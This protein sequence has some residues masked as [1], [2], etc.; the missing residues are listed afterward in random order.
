M[1]T[2]TRTNRQPIG[3][4]TLVL[5]FLLALSAFINYVD[6]GNLSVAAP[7]L[8]SELR[9]SA[10]QLGNLLAA[11]FWTYTFLMIFTGW[12]VDCFPVGW[13][14]AAG[15]ALWSFATVAT[16]LVNSFAML[17]LFRLLLG[18][19][20]SVSFPAYGKILAQHVA[21]EH[22]GI[23][24]AMVISGMSLGPAAGTLICGGLMATY[25]WRPVFI[26]VGLGSLLWLVPW[27]RWM[28]KAPSKAERFVCPASFG[29]IL[30]RRAFWGTGIGHF[31]TNYPFYLMI[32]WLPYYLVSERH[33]SMTQMARET[34][35]FYVAF[36]V[37]APIF[38]WIADS[39]VRQGASANFVRKS[40]LAIGHL[41]VAGSLL[42][43]A[44]ANPRISF[45]C[46]IIMG[47]GSGFIGPNIY[48][49]AQTLAGP[50]VAGRWTGLQNTMG[51]LVGVV[52]GPLT[53]WVVDRTGHF[54]WAFVVA[55]AVGLLG[56]VSWVFLTGP[57]A[58][59][60]WPREIIE[61]AEPLLPASS[62]AS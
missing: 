40:S 57:L 62:P 13:L 38:G 46:L 17:L 43:L 56:G 60:K 44:A 28:P 27:L 41:V 42:G 32:L 33:L 11:F 29:E 31:C 14:L 9:L 16:G 19:G 59:V 1:M 6:R 24:N 45:W 47:C 48:L 26:L 37:A 34:A 23:A 51:N 22:R 8:K 36:A 55:A 58:P 52:V 10:A 7:L 25:G 21:Q 30:G 20:E 53:G 50:S 61:G 54:W 18:I 39:F 5:L 49:F 15:L 35:C 4:R 3:G 2:R 12:M